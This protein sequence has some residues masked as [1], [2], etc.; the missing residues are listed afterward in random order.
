MTYLISSM[1]YGREIMK[2]IV[3]MS[4]VMMILMH[5]GDVDDAYV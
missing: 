5:D 2:V 4:M 1:Y 3:A